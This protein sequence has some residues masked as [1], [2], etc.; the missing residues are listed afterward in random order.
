MIFFDYLFYFLFLDKKK[1]YSL[2]LPR[3]K[4]SD[5]EKPGS[6]PFTSREGDR[7]AR[8]RSMLDF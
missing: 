5:K 8:V 7:F 1:I 3:Y 4:E 6:P 2:S